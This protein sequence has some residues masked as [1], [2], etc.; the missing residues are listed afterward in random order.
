MFNKLK[1]K[2]VTKSLPLVILMIAL[3]IFVLVLESGEFQALI[4]GPVAFESLA[5]D[6]IVENVIVE[7]SIDTNFGWFVEEYEENT[8]THATRSKYFYYVIWTG[9]DDATDWCYMGIKVPASDAD[10][11]DAMADAYYNGEYY[12]DT[13]EYSGAIEKMTDEEYMYFEEYFSEAG[14]TA[15]E[16]EEWT[17]PYY[18]N[19]GDLVGAS[20]VFTY[21]LIGIGAA[22][23]IGAI[24]LL[25]FALKGSGIKALKKELE[26]AG[27]SENDAEY[28]YENAKLLS[29]SGDIRIGRR[30]M[31]YM[32][33]SKAHMLQTDKIVW[34]YLKS[35]THRTNGIKT[36]TTY[37]VAIYT[38]T[39]KMINISVNKETIGQE[40]LK[41][42]NETM[43]WAVI[44]YSDDLNRMYFSDYPK[45]PTAAL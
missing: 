12:L 43:P 37:Q 42:M 36:G 41:Y 8:D 11:M 1:K 32:L 44:G 2:S 16:I 30:M 7:A 3:G 28:E 24:L 35:T 9:D 38:Y 45:L 27:F 5:P 22:L 21:I 18:I 17:L 6:E 31:F 20:A 14:W 29:K 33:G 26:D 10:A 39:K 15:E 34:A 4:K 25:V 23:V 13:M 40:I 19:V